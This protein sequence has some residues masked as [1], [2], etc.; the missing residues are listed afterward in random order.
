MRE[1]CK[2]VRET[3][4]I[5][6]TRLTLLD[7]EKRL[8]RY[9]L[10]DRRAI[11]SAVRNLVDQQELMYVNDFG[12]TFIEAALHK[13]IRI[14]SSIILKPLNCKVEQGAG[15]VVVSLC[16]GSSFGS[17][18]HPTTRLCLKG[19]EYF[20]GKESFQIP[21]K[22]TRALDIG[23]GTGVLII[24]AL[25]M[26]IASGIGL[27]IDP[28]AISEAQGNVECNGLSN[29]ISISA[30][31]FQKITESY[32]LIIANL[33]LPTLKSFLFQMVNRTKPGGVI[34]LSGIKSEEQESI[35]KQGQEME[36]NQQWMD[37]AHGW[38]AIGFQKNNKKR[39]ALS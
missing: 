15:D 31:A 30:Q 1:I 28:C 13:P 20:L 4:R 35:V 33:R 27:D 7:I 25:K 8:S 18:Q 36:L 17:G 37:E 3:I 38:V 11:R 5:V 10:S 12:H 6:E 16:H 39:C 19:I 26:G 9:G 29:R 14:T 21:G 32:N 23:T 34:L 22:N 24:T 2:A